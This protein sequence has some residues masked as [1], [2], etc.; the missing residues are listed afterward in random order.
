MRDKKIYQVEQ[1]AGQ[2]TYLLSPYGKDNMILPG[3]MIA[4]PRRSFLQTTAFVD[5]IVVRDDSLLRPAYL[6]KVKTNEYKGM[7]CKHA[8]RYVE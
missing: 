2:L 8:N 5:E 4:R 1:F 6:V 7:K 3:K